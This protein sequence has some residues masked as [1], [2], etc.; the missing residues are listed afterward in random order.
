MDTLRVLFP[1]GSSIRSDPQYRT[2]F[3][4]DP[5]SGEIENFDLFLLDCHRWKHR[6]V[7]F[8][9]N[10]LLSDITR[11]GKLLSVYKEIMDAQY[12]FIELFIEYAQC[13]CFIIAE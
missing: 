2:V 10:S 7:T 9:W 4:Q 8:G 11:S 5:V 12:L 1:V 13:I 6:S 3:M